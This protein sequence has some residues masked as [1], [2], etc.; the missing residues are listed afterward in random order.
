MTGTTRLT[1]AQAIV[2]Y[3]Q[4]QFSERD[5]VRRRVIPAAYGLF[6][7]GNVV[8]LGEAL[9][10]MGEDLPF[11]Q[12]KNEQAMVHIAIGFAKANRRLS[13]LACFASIGPGSTNMI[14]GAATATGNRVPVLLFPADTYANR[15]QG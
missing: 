2:R 3:L 11:Y 15:R 4:V 6:G 7:H 5:S 13:T 12:T 10:E 14:T 8:G 1:T 9:D